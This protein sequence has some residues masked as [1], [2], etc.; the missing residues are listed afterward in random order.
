MTRPAASIPASVTAVRIRQLQLFTVLAEVGSI[1][2]AAQRL[3]VTQPTATEMLKELE[4]AFSMQLFF[5]GAK[6]VTL[7]GQ[8]ERIAARIN[9]ILREL[10]WAVA[11]R[12]LTEATQVVKVGIV[13]TLIYSGLR[14]TLAR[15]VSQHPAIQLQLRQLTV[16]ECALALR[17]GEVDIALTLH[18]PA[19]FDE[20]TGDLIRATPLVES[21]MAVFA[22][23]LLELGAL[24]LDLKTLT[25]LP[26]ILPTIET[27]TR[28]MFEDAVLR[29][30]LTP[31]IAVM[32]VSPATLAVEL[33]RSMPYLAL[34][35]KRIND[36]GNF[37]HL[38]PVASTA[39]LGFPARFVFACRESRFEHPA[40]QELLALVQGTS[41]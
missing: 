40:V 4:R 11:E 39:D 3:H 1:S 20:T 13:P 37:P 10:Q 12:P 38:K 41:L 31:P 35:P 36:E 16:S 9:L 15:F 27:L 22:S 19:F 30:G 8:G 33:L 29:Q 32:E 5:R 14:A 24:R 2:K 28:R 17:N 26:W 23:E 34:L 6:G 18:H 25:G 21:Q 7:T